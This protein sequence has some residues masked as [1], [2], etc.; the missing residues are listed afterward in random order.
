V[1]TEHVDVAKSCRSPNKKCQ[2][3][4]PAIQSEYKQSLTFRVRRYTHLQCIWL[5][6]IHT[7]IVYFVVATKLVHR[8]QIRP[9][10]HN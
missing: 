8:L 6:T 9:T 10:V 2:I 4:E 3:T 1:S 7:C 5:Y